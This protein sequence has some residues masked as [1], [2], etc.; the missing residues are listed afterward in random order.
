MYAGCWSEKFVA[1]AA[2]PD[3][4][5]FEE[6][7]RLTTSPVNAR[8]RVVHTPAFLGFALTRLVGL[9]LRDVVLTRDNVEGLMAGLLTSDRTPTG[10]TRLGDWLHEYA[11]A[12][13][14]R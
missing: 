13:G 7:I 3:T 4:F 10:T 9:L 8:V 6:L 2:G 11:D 12:L 1:V 14:R 5:I